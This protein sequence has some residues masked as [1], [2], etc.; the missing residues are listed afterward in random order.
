M[1]KGKEYIVIERAH[2]PTIPAALALTRSRGLHERKAPKQGSV[3]DG[4]KSVHME[5]S[6]LQE[7]DFSM[8][9]SM[10]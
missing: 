3:H 2:N 1:K 9:E 5:D 7:E 6:Q 10:I 8:R 4:G